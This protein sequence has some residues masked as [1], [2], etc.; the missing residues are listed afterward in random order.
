MILAANDVDFE[1]IARRYLY[2]AM[3]EIMK[4][5]SEL[6]VENHEKNRS[7]FSSFVDPDTGCNE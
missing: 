5:Q 7:R 4:H 3:F 6:Y 2:Q 1:E